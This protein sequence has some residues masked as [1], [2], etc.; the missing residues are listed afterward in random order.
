MWDSTC[1]PPVPGVTPSRSPTSKP[2]SESTYSVTKSYTRPT[3]PPLPKPTLA[4]ISE[5]TPLIVD[6]MSMIGDDQTDQLDDDDDDDG[7]DDTPSSWTADS[8][9]SNPV[10]FQN[11]EYWDL[12]SD[13]VS[14]S[15]SS[16]LVGNS[17]Y[18]LLAVITAHLL[19]ELPSSSS[20]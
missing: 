17:I 14:S 1:P 9:G 16:C 6:G 11:A 20:T 13:I 15:D 19:I 5:A 7:K 3:F 2:T 12:W 18:F 10:D 8:S 4:T